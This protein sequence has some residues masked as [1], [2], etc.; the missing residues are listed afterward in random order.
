ML[1]VLRGRRIPKAEDIRMPDWPTGL[2]AEAEKNLRTVGT[3]KQQFVILGILSLVSVAMFLTRSLLTDIQVMR[4]QYPIQTEDIVLT[5]PAPVTRQSV[6][7]SDGVYTY[8]L[9]LSIFRSHFPYLQSYQCSLNLTPQVEPETEATKPLLVF[10]IKSHP[11]SGDRRQALR[12]T[13]ARKGEIDGYRIKPIFLLGQTE[14]HGQMDLVKLESEEF[15]DILQWDFTEG[16]HNLSLKERC[17]LEWLHLHLPHVEFIFKG[18]DDEFVNPGVV[19]QYI[20]EHGSDPRMLHGNLQHHATVLRGSKYAVSPELI[21]FDKYPHF[22]SGGGFMYSGP[23]VKILYEA[24]RKIPVFPLDDV[25]FGF[26]AL[27]AN[28]T[29]RNDERFHVFG[30]SFDACKYQRAIVVHGIDEEKLVRLWKIVQ[31]TK[32]N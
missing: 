19:V 2:K 10:A 23:S 20:K 14:V 18:D 31:S 28:L 21:P 11:G 6:N 8:H 30:L 22:L 7:L 24:S 9:D 4:R 1:Q 16:H 15:D 32:C 12:Q 13:W 29:F 3:M 5:T 17:F 25:Y 27:A 26:L